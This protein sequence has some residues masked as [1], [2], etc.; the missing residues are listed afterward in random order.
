[1]YVDTL[2]FYI[3]DFSHRPGDFTLVF[4]ENSGWQPS[5]IMAKL[6][7]ADNVHAEY[8]SLD[9]NLFNQTKGKSYNEMLLIDLATTK[10]ATIKEQNRFFKVTGRFPIKNLYRLMLEAERYPNMQFYCDCKDHSVY[11]W[12]HMPINGHAGE[13]RYYAVSL[14]FYEKHFRGHYAELNDYEGRS[15]EMFFLDVIRL[16]KTMGGIKCRFKTQA[17]LSGGGGHSLGHGLAFFHSTDNDSFA[18][19]SKRFLRQLLRWVMPWW[20]C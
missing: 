17:A 12:L 5:S 2:N 16:T 4:A 6:H 18:L 15:V 10:N 19:R 14:P 9:K 3:E 8:V 20:W 7:H 1:M 11:D 13:C